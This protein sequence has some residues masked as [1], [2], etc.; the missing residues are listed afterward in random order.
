MKK[1]ITMLLVALTAVS[2]AY[3]QTAGGQKDSD[4][5]VTGTFWDNWYVQAGLD[6]TL[7]NP[8]GKDFSQV[9]PKGK[10][11]GLNVAAGKWFSP[12]IGLRVRL[13]WEN[14]FPLFENK[15]VEWIATG[16]NGKSNMDS[17]GCLVA[18]IDVQLNL[19]NIFMGYEEDRKWNVVIYPKAGLTSNRATKSCSPMVGAGFGCT[20][21]L[22]DRWSLYA[23]MAYQMTTSD[24][25]SGVSG[26][27]MSVSTGSNGFL[28][29]HVGVQYDL[30]RN[31]GLRFNR[32][33]A[34]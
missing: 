20:Y 32:L 4:P 1:I 17:G 19:K 22:K 28:D 2:G 6:M 31:G 34:Y 10:S 8:Y 27:G 13:N 33:S 7:Q 16:D 12:E 9:F 24:Y 29:F 30:G 14:G 21:R 5:A 26:T 25:Y 23:D 18:S 15:H 11:F 3:S